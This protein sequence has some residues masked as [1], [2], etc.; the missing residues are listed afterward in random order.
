MRHGQRIW[1]LQLGTTTNNHPEVEGVDFVVH[2]FQKSSLYTL[3]G[4]TITEKYNLKFLHS[5]SATTYTFGYSQ[6]SLFFKLYLFDAA[7]ILKLGQGRWNGMKI[8]RSHNEY[9]WKVTKNYA[10]P[11]TFWTKSISLA[12]TKGWKQLIDWPVDFWLIDFWPTDFWYLM[13]SQ[14]RR[15]NQSETQVTAKVKSKRNTT[16]HK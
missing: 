1:F 7:V 16:H 13:P 4:S 15:S 11:G 10:T 12:K 14:P 6:Y 3:I 9:N 8:W 5:V 2:T